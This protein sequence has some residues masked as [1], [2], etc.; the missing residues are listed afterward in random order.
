M[1][2]R[3]WDI[4]RSLASRMGLIIRNSELTAW[5]A[6]IIKLQ[7]T[8]ND[9]RRVCCRFLF[10]T[11]GAKQWRNSIEGT[12][13]RQTIL[14]NGPTYLC[15]PRLHLLPILRSI[16]H[17]TSY[18]TQCASRRCETH[19]PLLGRPMCGAGSQLFSFHFLFLFF[20]FLFFSS[21]K[22]FGI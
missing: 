14:S 9:I 16:L 12:P 8:E 22:S 19:K 15:L 2:T 3:V 11:K 1:Y 5:V 6:T 18:S 21:I 13:P 17:A 20:F 7:E 4:L 10:G